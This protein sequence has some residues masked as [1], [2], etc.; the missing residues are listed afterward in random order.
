MSSGL[1]RPPYLFSHRGLSWPRE[2]LLAPGPVHRLPPSDGTDGCPWSS[3]GAR[4]WSMGT[5]GLAMGLG[6]DQSAGTQEA[7]M[8][9]GSEVQALTEQ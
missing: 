4:D 9:P 6:R 7:A 8:E 1:V 3:H 5:H 2:S